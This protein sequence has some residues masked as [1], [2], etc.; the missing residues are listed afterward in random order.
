M[1]PTSAMC[2]QHA[3][4]CI[5]TKNSNSSEKYDYSGFIP[6]LIKLLAK[7]LDFKYEFYNVS[8]YGRYDS[9]TK[10]WSGMIGEVVSNDVRELL[11]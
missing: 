4:F 10:K 5:V 11:V 3:P 9:N 2:T 1:L 6:D 8:A 7:R